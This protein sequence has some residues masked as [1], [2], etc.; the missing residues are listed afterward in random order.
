MA[1]ANDKLVSGTIRAAVDLSRYEV[2]ARARIRG[3]LQRLRKELVGEIS[4]RA[5]TRTAFN[6]ARLE[7]LLRASDAAISGTYKDVKG[8]LDVQLQGLARIQAATTTGVINEAIGVNL[9]DTAFTATQLKALVSDVLIEGAPSAEW[10]ARAEKATRER[11]S[12]QMRIGVARGETVQELV[13]RVRE[14]DGGLFGATIRE[15]EALVRTS[16]QTVA[17]TVRLETYEQNSDLFNGIQWVSTLDDRTTEICMALDGLQWDNDLNP[18][19]HDEAFPGPIAHWGCRSTQVP[20][21]KSWGEL[22]KDKDL[23][24]RLDAA[25]A[26]NPGVRASMDG[27]V[28]ARTTYSDWFKAQSEDRQRDILGDAKYEI[29]KREG[30][31]FRDMIDQRGNPLTLAELERRGRR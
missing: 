13:A 6:Q 26:E 22:L 12:D 17:N 21:L 16:V 28:A 1:G 27:E 7:Q 23:A 11:F 5:G 4:D 3:F 19:D 9:A 8:V 15:A 14:E 24:S 30:L 20:V 29:W 18:I 2:G 10:W 25:E 31:S